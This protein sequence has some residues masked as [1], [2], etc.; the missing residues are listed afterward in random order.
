MKESERVITDHKTSDSEAGFLQAIPDGLLSPLEAEILKL[1]SSGMNRNEIAQALGRNEHPISQRTLFARQ[2]IEEH[3]IFPAGLKR[4]SEYH[5]HPLVTA[6]S[7]GR[8]EGIKI[9][10][11]WYSTEELIKQYYET[12]RTLP[13]Y[14]RLLER[15]VTVGFKE[16]F[17]S[18]AKYASLK[19][20][21]AQ[22]RLKSKL[23]SELSVNI[24][25]DADQKVFDDLLVWLDVYKINLTPFQIRVLEMRLKHKG[26][27]EISRITHTSEYAVN[28]HL[29]KARILIDEELIFPAGIRR[30]SEYKLRFIKLDRVLDFLDAVYFLGRWYTTDEKVADYVAKRDDLKRSDLAS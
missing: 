3:V 2:K 19:R 21:E 1:H 14:P 11:I 16:W 8:L 22:K 9:L 25:Y 17:F 6:V 4:V 13:H 27:Q 26:H 29:S 20:L 10:N 12:K 7:A 18:T 5:D 24:I 15:G 28:T 23:K 30:L